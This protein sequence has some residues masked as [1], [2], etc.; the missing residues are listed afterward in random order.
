MSTAA[1]WE[2]APSPVHRTDAECTRH[3]LPAGDTRIIQEAVC[4]SIACRT[5]PQSCTG[6]RMGVFDD[7][8]QD[9]RC[10]D[11]N[12]VRPGAMVV[13]KSGAEQRCS[14][15]R[16]LNLGDGP[17]Q[18]T[19]GRTDDVRPVELGEPGYRVPVGGIDGFEH[20]DRMPFSPNSVRN[21]A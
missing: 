5:L 20:N 17:G 9:R 7:V 21:A 18:R 15:A 3:L 2:D 6:G 11:R 19:E 13:D 12:R 16:G 1:A 8:E 4:G 10:S 14:G